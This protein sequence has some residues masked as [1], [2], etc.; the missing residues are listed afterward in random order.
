MKEE[1]EPSPDFVDKVMARV[2]L[3]EARKATLR[4]RLL[5]SRPIRYVL[6]GGGTILG[7]LSAAPVF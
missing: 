5:A 2:Y 6:A 4:E 1:Y 3:L 7:I